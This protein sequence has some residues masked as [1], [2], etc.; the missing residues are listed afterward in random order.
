MSELKCPQCG[1]LRVPCYK[2]YVDGLYLRS[3]YLRQCCNCYYSFK[4]DINDNIISDNEP[5]S[6]KRLTSPKGL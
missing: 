4:T 6:Y 5:L 2:S 1:Y 3:T